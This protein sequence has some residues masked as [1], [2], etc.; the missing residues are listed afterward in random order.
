MDLLPRLPVFGIVARCFVERFMLGLEEAAVVFGGSM[1]GAS[2]CRR[3]VR[4]KYNAYIAVNSL[5][6]RG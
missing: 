1:T 3:M 4:T 5:A 6:L 2:A